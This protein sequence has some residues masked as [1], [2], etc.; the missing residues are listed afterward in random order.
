M[1]EKLRSVLEARRL[2]AGRGNGK[3]LGYKAWGQ[4]LGVVYTTLFR[5]S[6]GTRTIGIE[7]IRILA[8]WA[9]A[10]GD[11]ELLYALAEYALAARMPSPPVDN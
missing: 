1:D 3:P 9:T 11:A 10:N 8:T 2:A 7:S 5:F 4:K 6:K